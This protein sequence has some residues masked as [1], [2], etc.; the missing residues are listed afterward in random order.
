MPVD[1]LALVNPTVGETGLPFPVGEL[2]PEHGFYIRRQQSAEL[3]LPMTVAVGDHEVELTVQ[4]AG[5]TEDRY[6]ETVRFA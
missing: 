1:G 2:G 5:V 3:R 6:A 4:L